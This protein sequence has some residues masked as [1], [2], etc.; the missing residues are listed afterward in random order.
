[1]AGVKSEVA[2]RF[3]SCHVWDVDDVMIWLVQGYGCV[4]T[5]LCFVCYMLYAVMSVC[6]C[7]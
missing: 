2:R 3:T 1:M 7:I 5:C 6:T 4:R